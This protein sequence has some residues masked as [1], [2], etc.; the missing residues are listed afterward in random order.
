MKTLLISFLTLAVVSVVAQE[1]AQP[2]LT[3]TAEAQVKLVPNVVTARLKVEAGIYAK[4]PDAE[5]KSMMDKA[6]KELKI[7][8]KAKEFNDPAAYRYTSNN[9]AGCNNIMKNY[10]V[11]FGSIEE[12][13]SFV[14][15]IGDYKHAVLRLTPSLFFLGVSVDNFHGVKTKAYQAALENAKAKAEICVKVLGGEVGKPI[16]VRETSRYSQYNASTNYTSTYNQH[17]SVDAITYTSSM[18]VVFEL[19]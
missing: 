10:D 5:F 3:I 6:M 18:S 2:S 12:Y 7:D 16:S 17:K 14:K 9:G 19:K 8:G 4:E 13:E 1:T 11:S 15:Q